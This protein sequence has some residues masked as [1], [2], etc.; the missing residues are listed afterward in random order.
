MGRADKNSETSVGQVWVGG[1][2]RKISDALMDYI[3]RCDMGDDTYPKHMVGHH[4]RI[5]KE[6]SRI[7]LERL[8]HRLFPDKNKPKLHP[9]SLGTHKMPIR[10]QNQVSKEN[11]GIKIRL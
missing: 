2:I 1:I 9:A 5:I 10:L 3:I 6:Q 8:E 4:N 11:K 7:G